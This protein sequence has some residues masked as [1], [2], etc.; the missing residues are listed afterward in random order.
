[1][2]L[3]KF[4]EL[5]GLLDL[6][7]YLNP[8]D[9]DLKGT[10]CINKLWEK[11]YNDPNIYYF[12][13]ED[14]GRIVSSCTLIIIDNLTRRGRPFGL[15]ENVVTHKEY[16]K[17]GYGTAILHNAVEVA[18]KNNCYKVV[19]LTGRKEES[20]LRFYERVGFEK[21]IKTGFMIRL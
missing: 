21:D 4:E 18:K 1:V 16:R 12:V 19:L 14:D 13:V 6:Y 9:P 7:K 11:I 20:V 3:I 15:I 10:D 5:N 8:D 17:R 2:R